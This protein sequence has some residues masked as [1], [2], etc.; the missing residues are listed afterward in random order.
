MGNPLT[1]AHRDDRGWW[2]G[3]TNLLLLDDTGTVRASF[4]V[5][6]VEFG[7]ASSSVTDEVGGEE[8]VRSFLAMIAASPIRAFVIAGRLG[9]DRHDDRLYFDAQWIAAAD[10]DHPGRITS[11]PGD[12]ILAFDA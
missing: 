7:S 9:A 2:G 5:F 8:R 4:D 3:G 1:P 12:E 6:S 10:R 11:E